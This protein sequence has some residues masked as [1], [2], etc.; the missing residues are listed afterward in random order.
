[1]NTC[2]VSGSENMD[3]EVT[4]GL[5]PHW[6]GKCIS[7]RDKMNSSILILEKV[8]RATMGVYTWS[9]LSLGFLR[10]LP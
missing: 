1:M 6:K 8:M 5:F 7:T 3:S 10:M 9:L 4:K 2:H